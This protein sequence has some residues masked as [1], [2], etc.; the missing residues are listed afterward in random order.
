M[1]R[2]DVKLADEIPAPKEGG[3]YRITESEAFVSQVKQYKGIRVSMVDKNK[4]E[5]IETLWTRDVVGKNSKLGAFVTALGK[6]MATWTDKVI[7]FNNW[8]EGGRRI[9]VEEGMG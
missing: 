4:K 8:R 3:V 1:T 6:D 7:R 5:Y 9:T 2:I